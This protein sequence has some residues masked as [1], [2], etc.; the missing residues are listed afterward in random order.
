[1]IY[2]YNCKFDQNVRKK[3]KQYKILITKTSKFSLL[4]K[5]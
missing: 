1:M 4:E 5:K 2:I 3:Q